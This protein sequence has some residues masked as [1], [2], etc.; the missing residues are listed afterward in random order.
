ML[1]FVLVSALLLTVEGEYGAVRGST[2]LPSSC[3][4]AAQGFLLPLI[5]ILSNSIIEE[6]TSTLNHSYLSLGAESEVLQMG[7]VLQLE[8]AWRQDAGRYMCA[9][10][11]E[12]EQQGTTFTLHVQCINNEVMG[13]RD[14]SDGGGGGGIADVSVK[15]A[16]ER[17]E[18][19]T[20][21]RR[22]R[23]TCYVEGY[24]EPQ[25]SWYRN[26]GQISEGPRHRISA[27]SGQYHLEA[28]QERF[29]F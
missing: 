15:A 18:V 4:L 28:S 13:D 21:D 19:R 14:G 5:P 24:P 9:T 26:S 7:P 27:A 6:L 12:A 29:T 16:V 22:A 10:S 25:V 11:G 3:G 2:R 23:L 8:E 17:I 20:E 1:T